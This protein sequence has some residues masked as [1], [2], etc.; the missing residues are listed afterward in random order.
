MNKSIVA[1]TQALGQLLERVPKLV[2]NLG[3]KHPKAP[4]DFLQWLKEAEE[5][6]KQQN[7]PQASELA[8]V[9][10][11][12]YA[13]KYQSATRKEQQQACCEALPQAQSVVLALY[14]KAATPIEEA[15]KLLAPL[16][17]AM[18]QSSAVPFNTGDNFQHFIERL[19]QILNQ[20]EQ[21]KAS[22]VHV[23]ALLSKHD[24]LWVLAD[25]VDLEDWPRAA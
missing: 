15:R 11:T 7:A 19:S 5:C 24:C 14:E 12:L 25:M 2:D 17:S 4:E 20:H 1:R 16:L 9:R 22:M 8:A 13:K 3:A 6:L 10:S 18:A 23:N 21:L